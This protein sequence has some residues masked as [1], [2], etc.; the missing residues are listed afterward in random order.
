VAYLPNYAWDVFISYA[1]AD[2]EP[3]GEDESGWVSTFR[4]RLVPLIQSGLDQDIEV[5]F[6]ERELRSYNTIES[7]LSEVR[8]SALF[9]IVGSPNWVRPGRWC[10]QEINAFLAH[11]PDPSRIFI[12]EYEPPHP[13]LGYPGA[14]PNNERLFFWSDNNRPKVPVPLKSGDPT[15]EFTI[16][17]LA[18]D[19]RER[20]LEIAS[21]GSQQGQQ[22]PSPTRSH[23]V[24]LA[25]PTA[26][27]EEEYEELRDSLV[28]QNIEVLPR[29]PAPRTADELDRQLRDSLAL[30]HVYVQL[31]GRRKGRALEGS[32]ASPTL[33]QAEAARAAGLPTFSWRPDDVDP[34]KNP[35]EEYKALLLTAQN[36]TPTELA[37]AILDELKKI[38]LQ[39]ETPPAPAEQG[40]FRLVVS[41]D[42][43]D[44]EAATQLLEQCKNKACFAEA[45]VFDNDDLEWKQ[46]VDAHAV[47]F[48]QK[49]VPPRTV[50]ARYR[51]F[52]RVRTS[53][54]VAGKLKGQAL[55][56]FPPPQNKAK[57]LIVAPGLE[58]IDLSSEGGFEAFSQWIDRVGLAQPARPEG[59]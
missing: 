44:R 26:D 19:I 7:I 18:R 47:A 43:E 3:D 41:A 20:I 21:T 53:S 29:G 58:E 11:R 34:H 15:Y 59:E 45:D 38:A 57:G 33:M 50:M 2:N 31:L 42:P 32:E 1:H 36:G 10:Q 8:R 56:F 55:V 4:K 40:G 25:H 51:V 14:V 12:A 54:G 16:R 28:G 30:S 23:A 5:F 37:Q 9:V 22:G 17:K 39:A 24:F 52:N 49:D 46:W 35:D 48:V 6:D 13:G 27:V